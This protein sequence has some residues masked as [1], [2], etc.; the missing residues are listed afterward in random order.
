METVLACTPVLRKVLELGNI[1]VVV[2][3]SGETVPNHLTL[4]P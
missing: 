3:D 4:A 1:N 2:A